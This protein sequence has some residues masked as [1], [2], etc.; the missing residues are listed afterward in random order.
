MANIEQ[1]QIGTSL[2]A[3]AP[4]GTLQV[5][6]FI[7]S[8]DRYS[9]PIAQEA[10]VDECLSVLGT[11]FRGATAFPPGKG[12]WRDDS[13]GGE[14]VFDDTVMVTSYI[15]PDAMDDAALGELR[16]FLHRLGREGGQGEIGAVIGGAYFGITKYD[17]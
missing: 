14:L 4:S 17:S 3:G 5:T 15:D 16:R 7:P 11:L 10:W 6:I 13:R 12:V 1:G 9:V 8:V 2:G